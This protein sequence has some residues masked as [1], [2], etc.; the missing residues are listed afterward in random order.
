MIVIMAGIYVYARFNPE[1]SLF[2]PKC[3]V[4]LLTGYQCPGCGSQRAFFHLFHGNLLTAFRYNPLILALVPYIMTGIYLEY[5]ANIANPRIA[6]LRNVL[7]GKW[8]IVVLSVIIVL[9]TILRN[10]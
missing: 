4:Y 3:P 8:A 9:F 5:V 6:H 2:F 1:E 10:W 7:F